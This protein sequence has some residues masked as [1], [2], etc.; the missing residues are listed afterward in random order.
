M[1]KVPSKTTLNK[2]GL[3]AEEW[4]AILERQD[5]VCPVC[6]Q[7]PTTGRMVTDHEHVKKWR[8][9]PPEQ[10][11]LYVRGVTDWFCNHAYLGRGITVERSRNATAYLEAYE[12]RRP[13]RVR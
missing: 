1:V 8:Q 11:K 12:L 7:V 5:G 6:K 2:Y 9:M 10:R 3:T 4:L 13:P